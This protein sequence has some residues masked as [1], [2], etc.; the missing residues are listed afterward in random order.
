MN[1]MAIYK[2][3]GMAFHFNSL[4]ELMEYIM[5]RNDEFISLL[6]HRLVV[7]KQDGVVT[8]LYHIRIDAENKE[9][10]YVRARRS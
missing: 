3:T 4:S 1:T 5:Q 8:V 7:K 9:L 6:N 2:I 10:K